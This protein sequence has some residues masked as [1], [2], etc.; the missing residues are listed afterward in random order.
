VD[1]HDLEIIAT[2]GK[3]EDD[4]EGGFLDDVGLKNST[5]V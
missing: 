5:T 2:N 4:N 1:D 3:L